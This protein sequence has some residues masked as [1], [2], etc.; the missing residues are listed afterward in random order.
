MTTYLDD[1]VFLGFNKR[2]AA[3]DKRTGELIW[4]WTAPK[5]W[6]YVSLLLVDDETLIASVD[7]YTYRLDPATGH[8]V[9]Q[10]DLP[11][12]GTGVVSMVATG[13]KNPH[14]S[15][16]AAAAR[17]AKQNSAGASSSGAAGQG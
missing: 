14:D 13:L 15:V 1:M 5:G 2:V 16:I 9:W 4:E 6:S 8:Q 17:N 12:F 3:L 11:G 7:G 10:N